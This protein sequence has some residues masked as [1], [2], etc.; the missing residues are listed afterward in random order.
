MGVGWGWGVLEKKC[1]AVLEFMIPV[2]GVDVMS[3]TCNL[4]DGH[5]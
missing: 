5:L 4:H 3:K 1:L 2:V